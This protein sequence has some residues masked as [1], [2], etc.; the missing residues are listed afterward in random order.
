MRFLAK[1]NFC[2]T[3]TKPSALSSLVINK[4][5]KGHDM[6][7]FTQ[8]QYSRLLENGKQAN[9]GKNHYPVVK[10]FTPDANCTWLISE[11]EHLDIAFGLCDLGL[12]FPELGC[13]SIPELVELRGK[14]GLPVE[15][16]LHFNAKYPISVYARAA[17]FHSRIIEDETILQQFAD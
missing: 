9:S 16:D 1:Q 7:L 2:R 8:S 15:R 12:G 3:V 10:L 5:L 17:S 14:F 4:Q 6:K 13:V 11:I